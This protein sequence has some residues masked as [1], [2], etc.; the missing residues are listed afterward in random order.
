MANSLLGNFG[1]RTN[2]TQVTTCKD[3]DA[4]F[5]IILDGKRDIHNILP[6]SDGMIDMYHSFKEGV[7]ELATSTRILAALTTYHAR[8]KLYREGLDLVTRVLYMDTNL[9]VYLVTS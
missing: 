9:V 3:P 6:L 5:R 8:V 4:F 7:G 1:R 2:K